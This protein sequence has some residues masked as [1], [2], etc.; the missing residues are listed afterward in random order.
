[1]E[2]ARAAPAVSAANR[3]KR[4]VPDTAI[5]GGL[6]AVSDFPPHFVAALNCVEHTERL[7]LQVDFANNQTAL[8][9]EWQ[10]VK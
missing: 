5:R 6:D 9:D 4:L 3:V 1:M 10:V 7:R 8:I 2:A